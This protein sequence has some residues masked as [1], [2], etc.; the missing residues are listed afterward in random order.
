MK[1]AHI[2]YIPNDNIL[3]VE[4]KIKNQSKAA[5]NLGLDIDFII[6]NSNID[7]IENNLKLIKL[8]SSQNNFISKIQKKLF[9][10]SLISRSVDLNEY[11]YII[12]RYPSMDFSALS[13]S[14]KWGD[15]IITEHHTDEIGEMNSEEINLTIKFKIFLEKI[16]GPKFLRNIRGLIAVTDEIRKVELLKANKNIYSS[17]ISN[18]ISIK[19]VEFTQFTKF[20]NKELKLIF[21]ASY[22]A[23]WHGLD[24]LLK[25]L[26]DY[27]DYF[28]IKLYLIGDLSNELKDLIKNI[29]NNKV[30]I[31][32][33][34][35]KY[36][37]EL[38]YYFKKSNIAI[39]SLALHRNNMKE[40]CVLKTREY[41]ARGIPFVY[42]Y[43]D[44][45]LIGDNNFSLKLSIQDEIDIRV[46]LDFVIK[47]KEIDNISEIERDFALEYLDWQIKVKKMYEFVKVL[48]NV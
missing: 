32:I 20:D 10:F 39:S 30:N 1:I 24:L 12:L 38:N 11:D 4:K 46:I 23:P 45:D 9:K 44:S 36:G 21:V 6:L 28:D 3:G 41:I 25:S 2:N 7:K 29:G 34:G 43:D 13:F 16:I 42:R 18:G 19:D 40:A 47:L 15:K 27:K 5:L 17:V 35:R 22:F 26:K 37:E 48:S 14:R 31:K 8:K 33:L